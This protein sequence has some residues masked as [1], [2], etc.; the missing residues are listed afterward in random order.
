[1]DKYA[2]ILAA[3]TVTAPVGLINIHRHFS[4]L[5]M[6]EDVVRAA[7]LWIQYLHCKILQSCTLSECVSVS[8]KSK[9]CL[10]SCSHG[11]DGGGDSPVVTGQTV[12]LP[13]HSP[14]CQPSQSD[15]RKTKNMNRGS[16]RCNWLERPFWN[17]IRV[18]FCISACEVI[19][20][21][22]S[23]CHCCKT[24]HDQLRLL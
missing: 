8:F 17:V 6:L 4:L 10:F 13:Q 19:P 12:C 23:R 3:H 1:M 14:I 15:R 16:H 11:G 7:Q 24:F 20:I 2:H 5:Q 18:V 21:M 22:S 9:L